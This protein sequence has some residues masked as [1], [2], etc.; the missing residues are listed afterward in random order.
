MNTKRRQHLTGK[1]LTIPV[2]GYCISELI[3]EARPRLVFNDP[4]RSEIDLHGEFRIDAAGVRSTYAPLDAT[5]LPVLESLQLVEVADARASRRG[6]LEIRFV[7]DRV[8]VVEDGPYE[9]WHYE[10]AAGLRIHGGLA[11]LSS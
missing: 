4:G 8:L 6:E 11:G 10:N 3:G 9:N 5:T 1:R 7:D 2:R